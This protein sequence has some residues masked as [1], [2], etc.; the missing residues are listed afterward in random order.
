MPISDIERHKAERALRSY[1][2]QHTDPE[3]R[4]K[5]EIVYRFEGNRVYLAERRP[6]WQNPSVR[7]DE[8]IAQFRFG[9]ATG[10]WTLYY[11]DRHLKWHRLQG[12]EPSSSLANLLPV[13]DAEPI[14]YG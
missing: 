6:D 4:Q 2:A 12:Y 14:F 10:L 1:C 13:V 8:D 11:L 5:L 7:K 3:L 9:V